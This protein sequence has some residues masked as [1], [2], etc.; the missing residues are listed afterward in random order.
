MKIINKI[1]LFL[2][3]ILIIVSVFITTIDIISFNKEFYKVE[4]SKLNVYSTI[5]ISID[6]L[7][8]VTNKLLGY[9]K[10][11][12]KDIKI[13]ASINGNDREVFNEKETLHMVDVKNL[14]LSTINIRNLS[15]IVIIVLSLVYLII[16]KSIN[17]KEFFISFK[18]AF[19]SI[20]LVVLS[21]GVYAY[22]DFYNFWMQFHYIFFTNDLFLLDPNLDILI[23]MV[24]QQFFMDLI[25]KI[26]FYFVLSISSIFIGLYILGRKTNDKRSII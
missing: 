10:N 17:F 25:F 7:D 6:D 13:V 21:L 22:L 16:N 8:K 20:L 23:M 24:P 4:Y 11:E 19:I 1:V 2:I 15:V 18:S 12:Y 14:Y 5:G 26:A 9:I 3:S